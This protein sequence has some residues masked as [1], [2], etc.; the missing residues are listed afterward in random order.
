MQGAQCCGG[1]EPTPA[2]IDKHSQ[3]SQQMFKTLSKII[4]EPFEVTFQEKIKFPM[5]DVVEVQNQLMHP[6]IVTPNN[7]NR[8]SKHYLR[9]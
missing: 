8:S 9:S 5:L 1:A 4:A 2:P 7:H 3:Q 6:L